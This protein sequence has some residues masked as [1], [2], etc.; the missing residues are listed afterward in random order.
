MSLPTKKDRDRKYIDK[1]VKDVEIVLYTGSKMSGEQAFS[2]ITALIPGNRINL[3]TTIKKFQAELLRFDSVYR[4]FIILASA[5][6]ELNRF[7]ALKNLLW[8][9]PLILILPDQ[10]RDLVS[11]GLKLY[12]RYISYGIR[13]FKDVLLVLE[14]MIQNH[15]LKQIF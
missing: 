4:I 8:G 12:P 6:Y 1:T 2:S 15:S 5:E 7:L 10:N 13:D 3:H 14:K 11:K 9:C